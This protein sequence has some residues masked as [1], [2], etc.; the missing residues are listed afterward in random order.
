MVVPGVHIIPAGV[1]CMVDGGVTSACENIGSSLVPKLIHRL[2]NWRYFMQG[3]VED[4]GRLKLAVL[5]V[6]QDPK[7]KNY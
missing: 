1:V 7:T 2:L 3:T 6:P 5:L 4:V